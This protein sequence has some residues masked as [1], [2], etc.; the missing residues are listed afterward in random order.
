MAPD[1]NFLAVW[2]CRSVQIRDVTAP[3]GREARGR[4]VN[5]DG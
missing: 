5:S 4:S 3:P 1:S 2:G